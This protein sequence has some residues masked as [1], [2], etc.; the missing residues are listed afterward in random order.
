MARMRMI[1]LIGNSQPR[2]ARWGWRRGFSFFEV[3]VT[4]TVFSLGIV[5]IQKAML[6][7]IDIRQHLTN[8]L[9]ARQILD[10]QFIRAQNQFKKNGELPVL[11]NGSVMPVRLNRRL[12]PFRL[13]V[14]FKQVGQGRGLYRMDMAL[15]WPERNRTARL[16]RSALLTD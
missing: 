4:L 2:A 1:S 16:Q 10:D 13:S 12:I 6:H 11:T 5:M 9:Y 15:S 8:R 7:A 14:D 3:M